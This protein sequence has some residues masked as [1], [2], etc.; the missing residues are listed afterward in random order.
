MSKQELISEKTYQ[1]IKNDIVTCVLEPGQQIAQADLVSRYRVGMTPVRE[2]LRQLTQEG[3]INP[4][5][6]LGYIVSVI[7]ADDV[8]EIYEMRGILETAVARLA[9]NRA[10]DE[11][12]KE[13]QAAANF[14]YVYKNR[15][16][17]SDFLAKNRAFHLAIANAT[18]NRRLTELVARGLDELTR[19]F[20]L[21][22]DLR[23]SADEMRDDHLAIADALCKRDADRAVQLVQE[24]IS[25][26]QE[27][28]A[29]ALVRYPKRLINGQITTDLARRRFRV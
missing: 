27:R 17:Y 11:R 16:S 14:T 7:T 12:L 21:G 28:V 5:P 8:A 9:A 26:S 6:R 23:D 20:H 29:Q 10:H 22:L 2:A 19:V 13:I 15:Q 3:F 18:E 24:E 4:V 1:R 25:R